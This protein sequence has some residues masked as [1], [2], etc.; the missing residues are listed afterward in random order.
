M[1][2]SHDYMYIYICLYIFRSNFVKVSDYKDLMHSKASNTHTRR[3]P[4]QKNKREEGKPTIRGKKKKR[5]K[6][7]A[8]GEVSWHAEIHC[9]K[10]FVL[11][12]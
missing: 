10:L 9:H 2:E 11:R 12:G 8:A 4:K 7:K 6:R 5:K 3:L 1:K